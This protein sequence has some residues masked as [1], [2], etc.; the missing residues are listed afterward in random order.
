MSRTGRGRGRAR[1]EIATVRVLEKRL[2][3]LPVVAE[4]GRRLRIA[5]IIDELCPIRDVAPLSHGEVVEVLVANRLTAPAPMVQVERWAAAMAVDEAYGV[6]PHLLN[7]DRLARAL[8]A[9][10]PHLDEITGSVGAAA[11]TGFGVDASRLHWDMTSISLYGAYPQADGEY[12]GPRWG[13]PKDRRPDLRQVQAGLAVSGDGGIPVF[14]RA[15]DGGAAEVSQVVGAMTAL[16]QIAGPRGFL[17]VG[18]SKLISYANAAAMAAEGVSFVAPLAASRVPPGLFA[19]LPAGA[20]T[21]VDYTA[22]RDAGKPAGARGSYRVLEDDGMDLPGPR[23]S[24]PAVHLRRILVYSSANATGAAKARAL[25]LAKSAEDL[26]RLVRTA[27]TR[28]HPDAGAVAARLK[29][30]STKRRVTAYLRAQVTTNDGKPML[31]W[32]FDQAAINAET[33]SDGWY[34]LLANL[35]PD[36]AD[37]AEIFRRY[38]GQQV[39]ERRY[40]DFKGP[41]AVAPLFLKTNR[42]ITALITVICLALLIF[43]LIERQVRKALAP[44]G[45]MMSG[46]PGYGPALARPTGKTIFEA[47]GDL[48]LI[49]AHDENPAVIPKPA[50]IQARLLDLLKIDISRPRWLTQ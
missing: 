1:A 2:G 37:P 5:E 31:T 11:I 8:D 43:C 33:A 18:D 9:I 50:G 38:K 49:P 32:H 4:F 17:M 7:D 13:H 36:Q 12:P 3:A 27:G 20:G 47:L 21:P 45:G 44:H 34:A 35:G 19:A 6:E 25:K 14:H 26:N 41:L 30:I 10:A 23:R 16:R 48:R 40:G 42:R 15:Y 29:A 22:A 46:L 28:F 39:V 24:D